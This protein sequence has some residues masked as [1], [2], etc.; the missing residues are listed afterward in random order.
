MEDS[1]NTIKYDKEEN[2]GI[3]TLNRPE[4][5]NAISLEMRQ[6]IGT[7]LRKISQDEQVRVVILTGG[8]KCFCAGVDL[9]ESPGMLDLVLE[10]ILYRIVNR[11]TIIHCLIED[12]EK[13]V[14]AAVS[15][16]ALGGGCELALACDFRIASESAK[17]GLPEINL[18]GLPAGGGTQRLPRLIGVAKAKEMIMT[19]DSIDS[20]EAYRIG[21][22]NRVVPVDSLLEEAKKIAGRISEKAPLAMKM[23]KIA[24]NKG[25]QMDLNSGLDY[26]AQCVTVL[27]KTEDRRE[28]INAF[29][30]KRKPLFKGR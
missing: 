6:E 21:L 3:I 22:V 19:G 12:F 20:R 15:G 13:P 27:Y 28:A 2:I 24:I 8:G 18:G 26:E 5:L 1:F 29:K 16:I 9:K 7:L 14:I 30:E 25:I 23:A 17:F 11:K 10:N 4:R